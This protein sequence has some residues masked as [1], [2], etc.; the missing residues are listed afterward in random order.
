MGYTWHWQV[1]LQPASGKETYLDWLLLGLWTTVKMGALAWILA[2][3]LG[4][5]LGVLRTVP[6]RLL[7]RAAGELRFPA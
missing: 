2:F 5:L 4:S 6:N 1:F 7:S 3:V